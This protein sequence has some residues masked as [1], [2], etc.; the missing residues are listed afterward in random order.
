LGLGWLASTGGLNGRI[1]II[2]VYRPTEEK[3]ENDWDP[4]H[5]L[6][7]VVKRLD[8]EGFIITSSLTDKIKE[9]ETIWPTSE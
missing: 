4:P 8:G 7:V 6:T 2:T 9:G 5:H 1:L 3:W